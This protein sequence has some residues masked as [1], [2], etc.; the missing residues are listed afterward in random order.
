MSKSEIGFARR[1]ILKRLES[2]HRKGPKSRDEAAKIKAELDAF[3][4]KY[5]V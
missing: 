3:N 2:A 4:D 5:P 1:D